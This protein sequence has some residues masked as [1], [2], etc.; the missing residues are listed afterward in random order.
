MDLLFAYGGCVVRTDGT[1]TTLWKSPSYGINAVGAVEDLDGDGRLE[2]VCSTGYEVIV[3]ASESGQLLLKY[4][5]GFP[6]SSGTQ[7][8][9]ILCHRF[10]K[11]SRGMHLIVPLMSAKEVLVFDFRNGK[12]NGVLAHTLWMVTTTRM[13]M[14]SSETPERHGL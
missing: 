8:S 14:P 4:Y 10:D 6:L 12:R 2:I 1:G 3:L 13:A 9:T 11:K 7:A 5:V